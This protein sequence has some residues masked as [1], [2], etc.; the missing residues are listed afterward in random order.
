MKQPLYYRVECP[1]VIVGQRSEGWAKP[2]ELRVV[3]AD[4]A[5]AERHI[6]YCSAL[7]CR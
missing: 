1:L 6:C 4:Q 5:G 2:V 7:L 3:G